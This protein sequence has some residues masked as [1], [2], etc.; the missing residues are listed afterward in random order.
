MLTVLMV[1]AFNSAW[2]HAEE[3]ETDNNEAEPKLT[4]RELHA[5]LNVER[6]IHS[7]SMKTNPSKEPKHTK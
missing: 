7:F 5:I 1:V 4:L 2:A 3:L 6:L